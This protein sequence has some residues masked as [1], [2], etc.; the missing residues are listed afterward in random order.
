MKSNSWNLGQL[1]KWGQNIAIQRNRNKVAITL[2]RPVR[3]HA[4][5]NK[6]KV[7]VQS[8]LNWELTPSIDQWAV[9]STFF[10]G[11]RL[12]RKQTINVWE[13]MTNLWLLPDTI[14]LSY[15]ILSHLKKSQ[16]NWRNWLIEDIV[17][18][19]NRDSGASHRIQHQFSP[20]QSCPTS[21]PQSPEFQTTSPTWRETTKRSD[22]AALRAFLHET[23][24]CISNSFNLIYL[25]QSASK[26]KGFHFLQVTS[27]RVCKFPWNKSKLCT[28]LVSI[29]HWSTVGT[30][31]GTVGIHLGSRNVTSQ[32]QTSMWNDKMIHHIIT[33]LNS[34]RAHRVWP[35]FDRVHRA[36]RIALPRGSSGP[37]RNSSPRHRRR[38]HWD[39]RNHS[40]S[41]IFF[42]KYLCDHVGCDR[43]PDYHRQH[44][45]ICVHWFHDSPHSLWMLFFLW[46]ISVGGWGVC[47][48]GVG[49]VQGEGWGCCQGCFLEGG[50]ISQTPYVCR[51]SD[52]TAFQFSLFLGST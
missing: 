2:N 34:K 26:F 50:H 22:S 27:W 47:R 4:W 24:F 32:P 19:A 12:L 45:L 5:L 44:M 52:V 38:N 48:G 11:E 10:G 43:L 7:V 37:A 9:S 31:Q 23:F 17:I 28:A 13:S 15:P 6:L 20:Q 51:K 3:R 36:L 39:L 40:L 21:L 30:T 18:R 33:S 8:I 42:I 16:R 25:L 46:Q 41:H 35:G 29:R 1:A 49:G 14:P